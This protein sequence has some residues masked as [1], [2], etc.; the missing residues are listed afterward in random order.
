MEYI[1]ASSISEE[2]RGG[3]AELEVWKRLKQPFDLDEQGVLY[4]Q[5]PII[6]KQGQRFDRKPDF[7]LLHEELG[8]LIVECK[9]YQI[10]HIDYIEGETWYLRNTRQNTA[11][12]MEQA[13]KQGFHL[14]SFFQRESILREGANVKIPMN[15][16]VALPNISREEW[17]RRDFEGPAAPRVILSDDLT[18][19]ALRERLSD[20]QT[21][22]PLTSEEYDA[23]RNVLS[24][25]QPISGNPQSPN[26][27][28]ITDTEYYEQVKQGLEGLDTNQQE[29]GMRI[30]DGPQQIR[31]IAG[32]GK[33]VLLAM[34][35]ARMLSEHDDWRIAVTFST[36][37]LYEHITSLVER[38]YEH[39]TGEKLDEAAG[40][41]DIIHG[42][43]G[44]TTG[45]GVYKLI[46]KHTSK[47]TALS[48]NEA[49]EKFG[50]SADLQEAVSHD[51]RQTGDIPT[52]WDAILIDEAQDFG[53]E[54]FNMCLEALDKNNRLIWAY[55]EAQDL[56]SLTAPSP[57]NIFGTDEMGTSVVDLSGS[58]K[59][60]IQ[61]S[62]IMRKSYR[63]P[64]EVLMTAHVLGMGL[65]RS[66]GP[67]QTITRQDGWENLGY[68]IDGDFRKTGSKAT[69]SRPPENSPH[70][71]NETPEAAPFIQCER[72]PSKKPELEWVA[73]QIKTDIEDEGLSPE[74][75]LVIPLGP[76]AKGHGHHI[77]REELNNRG[78]EINCVWNKNNKVFEKEDQVTVSRINRAKGNEAASVYVV[79]L[80]EAMNEEYRGNVVRRR[81]E[82]FVA[83]TRSR[84]WCTITGTEDGAEILDELERTLGALRKASPSVTFEI[85]DVQ[86]LDNELEKDTENI[87]DTNITDFV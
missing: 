64:R 7:V 61:K 57:K 67:I 28:P 38:F 65:K 76:N 37:S 52:I 17:E 21:F 48:V 53:P 22:E 73:E 40:E 33:T 55:D 18:P 27:D 2:D 30:P 24:C 60:G 66:D 86:A 3:V 59:D 79:G 74:Q 50:W 36:K 39:F 75:I 84:A 23:A 85:P 51:V 45:A 47:A 71:L 16:F 72:F 32:S 11:S 58:Y 25:G 49:K 80:E 70:P 63:A 54:F 5:Y 19:A 9:G 31:G 41:I 42:W 1:K 83:I 87:Q 69:L 35:A 12:P 10:E 46:A 20:I 14:L 15:V 68:K 56:G 6:E 77:L 34:K 29:I 62:H 8:L 82:V 44:N 13:R 81:N 43:G 4:H 26:S 78:I